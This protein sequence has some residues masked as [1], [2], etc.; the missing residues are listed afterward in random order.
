MPVY[1]H[2]A[3]NPSAFVANTSSEDGFDDRGDQSHS[4]NCVP[5]L[6]VVLNEVAKQKVLV[7]KAYVNKGMELTFPMLKPTTG[8]GLIEIKYLNKWTKKSSAGHRSAGTQKG[9]GGYA[10]KAITFTAVF[11]DIHSLPVSFP[12]LTY[13]VI[14]LLRLWAITGIT[15]ALDSRSYTMALIMM[16][17][18]VS[19]DQR[20]AIKTAYINSLKEGKKDGF[21]RQHGASSRTWGLTWKGSGPP[22]AVDVPAMPPAPLRFQ[23]GSVILFPCVIK[24]IDF[25][26]SR[27]NGIVATAAEAKIVLQEVTERS[28]WTYSA[29]NPMSVAAAT[30]GGHPVPPTPPEDDLQRLIR[31]ADIFSSEGGIRDW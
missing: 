1:K 10:G 22:E 28:L 18:E 6:S 26:I 12:Y 21:S 23:F 4:E 13:E 8:G 17:K 2:H 3:F 16:K 20:E 31:H 25:A 29:P 11:D 7:P 19:P 15:Q 14:E 5:T 9:Y 24:Q 30:I 27:Y